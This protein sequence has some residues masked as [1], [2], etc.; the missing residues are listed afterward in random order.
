MPRA[1]QLLQPLSGKVD[2]YGRIP[3]GQAVPAGSYTDTVNVTLTF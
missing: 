3:S 2:V 1:V